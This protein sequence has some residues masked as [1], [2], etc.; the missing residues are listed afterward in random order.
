M[1]TNNEEI[2]TVEGLSS[3]FDDADEFAESSAVTEWVEVF[4]LSRCKIP[5][6]DP[7]QMLRFGGHFFLLMD[8]K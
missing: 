5:D 7:K 8:L 4:G 2:R 6:I 3:L 1:K